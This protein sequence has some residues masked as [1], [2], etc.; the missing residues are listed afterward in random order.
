[1]T[2]ATPTVQ[3]RLSGGYGF[4]Q[5]ERLIRD[6]SPLLNLEDPHLLELDLRG[7]AFIGPAGL[8]LVVATMK[9]TATA[10]T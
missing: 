3:V 9:R 5:L 7:L 1:M 6:L 10:G 4:A 2:A 8:A